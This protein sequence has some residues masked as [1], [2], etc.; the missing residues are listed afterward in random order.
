M[1]IGNE[2]IRHDLADLGLVE[3]GDLTHE[4]MKHQVDRIQSRRRTI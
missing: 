3:S 4:A 1:A 2:R